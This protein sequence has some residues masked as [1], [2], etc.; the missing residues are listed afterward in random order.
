M[1]NLE[2]GQKKGYTLPCWGAW[3]SYVRETDFLYFSVFPC[4]SVFSLF[5]FFL[6]L[7]DFRVCN[8]PGSL[9]STNGPGWGHDFWVGM[10]CHL[11]PSAAF[12]LRL[13][14]GG[15]NV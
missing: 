2:G 11:F 14:V 9:V 5:H 1:G 8:D 15:Q 13:Q 7:F 12:P 10:C 3:V 4:F 6:S